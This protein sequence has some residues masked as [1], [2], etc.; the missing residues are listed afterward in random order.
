VPASVKLN[1]GTVRSNASITLADKELRFICSTLPAFLSPDADPSGDRHLP[2][3]VP[4]LRTYLIITSHHKILLIHRSFLTLSPTPK[5]S[6]VALRSQQVCINAAR[7]IL[8]QIAASPSPPPVWTIPYHVVGAATVVLIDLMQR[9]GTARDGETD[10]KRAEV[11]AALAA[12]RQLEIP[13][14]ISCRGIKILQD[15]VDEEGR[16]RGSS[17]RMKRK[18]EGGVGGVVKRMA[19]YVSSAQRLSCLPCQF[20]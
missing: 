9:S 19:V 16:W 18:A 4:A 12:L 6:A 1:N 3:F 13:S 8:R 2:A 5:R 15:L 7:V 17:Y 14:T 10:A 20:A 11:V